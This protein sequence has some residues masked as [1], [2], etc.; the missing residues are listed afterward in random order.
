[1]ELGA[2]DE[3]IYD[4]VNSWSPRARLLLFLIP[5][6]TMYQIW[7]L[8][9]KFFDLVA[10]FP[11]KYFVLFDWIQFTNVRL[12]GL[13]IILFLLFF[14]KGAVAD[15]IFADPPDKHLKKVESVRKRTL[16]YFSIMAAYGLA[17]QIVFFN[18]GYLSSPFEFKHGFYN[19]L[20]LAILA[21]ISEEA[22]NR[23]LALYIITSFWG[24]T[25]GVVISSLLFGLSHDYGII[26][27]F[28][29]TLVGA[30]LALITMRYG[31]LLP[32][33]LIHSI[34]N[35]AVALRPF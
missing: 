14:K 7:I 12:G 31:S 16:I 1:M 35:T 32:A 30:L 23:F 17:F 18:L 9:Y 15:I 2:R 3:R 6:A 13:L 24:R 20:S 4:L 27:I 22:Q 25:A 28:Q 8:M 34:N 33:I 29:M 5:I 21:P 10:V 11:E 26:G 19:Y